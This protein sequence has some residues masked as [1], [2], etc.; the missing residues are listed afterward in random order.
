MDTNPSLCLSQVVDGQYIGSGNVNSM[1]WFW[2]WGLEPYNYVQTILP[3][4]GPSCWGPA[5]TVTAT[6]FSI[7]SMHSSGAH[8]LLC[9]G[10]VRFIANAIDVGNSSS[11]PVTSGRSP[12]G[13]WGALGSKSGSEVIGEF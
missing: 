11:A 4:N 9:D 6:I 5:P 10:A 2:A 7:S 12:Y 13:V 1:G 3:P 8:V